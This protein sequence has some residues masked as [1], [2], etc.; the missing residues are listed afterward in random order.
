MQAP[1]FIPPDEPVDLTNCD[2]EPIHIPGSIQPHGAL[3]AVTEPE[4][5]VVQASENTLALLGIAHGEILGA[6]LSRV[7]DEPGLAA[8]HDA[9]G[10]VSP[11]PADALPLTVRGRAFDGILYRASGLLVLE[12]EP[13]SAPGGDSAEARRL[14]D[15]RAR[16]G[17]RRM[18]EMERLEDLWPVLATLVREFTGFD[19]VMVYRFSERDGSGEVIA[20]QRAD[21]LEP[22]LGLHYPATDVP[23]QAR[24]LY[25]L[26]RLRLV[27][28]AA[29]S[30]VAVVPSDSPITGAPLDLSSSVLRSVSPIHREYLANI[31]VRASMSVSLVKDEALFGL[32]ACHHR[33]PRFVR[34][35]TRMLC[36]FLSDVV[37]WMLGPKLESEASRALVHANAVQVELVERMSTQ[38]DFAAALI[39]PRPSALDL[40][41]AG[42]LAVVHG[43]SITTTGVTPKEDQI[44]G[45]VAWLRSGMEGAEIVTEELSAAYPPAAEFKD[46]ASGLLAVAVSK[47]QG[48]FLLWFRPESVREVRWGGDPRKAVVTEGEH[49]LP[50]RSFAVWTERVHGRSAPWA[51]WEVTAAAELRSLTATVILQKAAEIFEL[52]NELRLALQ[53]RDEFLSMASHELK[54]PTTTLRLQLEVLRR[55]AERGRLTPDKV[56]S[57][58]ARADRQVDRL[59]LLIG[60]LL[61]VSRISAGRLELERSPVDLAELAREVIERF[62]ES[63]VEF[64]VDARGDVTGDWDRF[65][66]DQ[67]LTNLG[68]NAVKYG[69][70]KPVEFVLRDVGRSVRCAVRDRGI[71]ISPEAQARLFERFERAVS[72]KNYT[73]FGLGLWIT[74]QIVERHGGRIEVQSAPGEGSTFVFELPR[75]VER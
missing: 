50:R 6:P 25:V 62:G 13:A 18:A 59:E 38:P 64:R 20:E 5:V 12:L 71:G 14:Y 11:R 3:L 37:S 46:T 73:G 15:D 48:V 45:L 55:W 1:E 51:A 52:N 57:S 47:A 34:H 22:Y 23:R 63:G 21:D 70:G 26:S 42:G 19:R 75:R 44:A 65:R 17:L 16:E 40:V 30:P 33:T 43:E 69:D 36:E 2:R 31:D 29:Y 74:R 49:L 67:V 8:L 7:L 39:G 24:R 27:P 68:S 4:L 32:V 66:I 41:G 35:E 9:R 58:V 60:Q 56:L 28:D 72:P 10:R 61:D 54:T 53:S